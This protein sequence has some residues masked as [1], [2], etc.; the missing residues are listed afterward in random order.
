[1]S[2]YGVPRSYLSCE[3]NRLMLGV[4]HLPTV[5]LPTV[6]KADTTELVES[7]SAV[8]ARIVTENDRLKLDDTIVRPC[9]ASKSNARKR[10]D[11]ASGWKF[12]ARKYTR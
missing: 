5:D 2:D 9:V 1:M 6:D 11:N 7:P 4:A 3:S 8:H 12:C 10:F